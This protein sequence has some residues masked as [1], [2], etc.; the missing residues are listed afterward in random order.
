MVVDPLDALVR[1]RRMALDETRRSLSGCLAAEDA[2]AAARACSEA[3]IL[4]ERSAVERVD[5]DD[6]AVEA[7]A[8]WLPIGRARVRHAVEVHDRCMADTAR[9]R[10]AVAVARAAHEAAEELLARK[11]DEQR[12]ANQRQEQRVVDEMGARSRKQ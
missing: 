9:A 11:R 6:A 8:A 2:S 3:V 12:L 4:S 5:T 1:V 7:F 10:A